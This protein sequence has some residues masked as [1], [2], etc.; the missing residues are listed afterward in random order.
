MANAIP[1]SSVPK[2]DP[3]EPS[4]VPKDDTVKV[5][6]IGEGAEKVKFTKDPKATSIRVYADG[7][8]LVDY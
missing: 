3:K 2:K 6:Y 7:R 4:V 5:E 1:A 8:I